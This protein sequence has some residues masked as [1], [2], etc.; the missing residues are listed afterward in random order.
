[1][2]SFKKNQCI[3]M[4]VKLHWKLTTFCFKIKPHKIK[5]IFLLTWKFSRNLSVMEISNKEV[6]DLNSN[7]QVGGL[8]DLKMGATDRTELCE[9]CGLGCVQCAGHHGHI[10]LPVPVYHPLYFKVCH[11]KYK[12]YVFRKKGE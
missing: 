12:L 10:E 9:T 2:I 4:S 1:M 11:F 8:Y 5:I 3:Y 7:A 6:F